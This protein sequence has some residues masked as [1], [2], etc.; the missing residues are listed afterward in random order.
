MINP[1]GTALKPFAPGILLALFTILFGFGIGV[2]F[3]AAEDSM[4]AALTDSG[5]AVLDTVY[6]GDV[7]KM[8]GVVGKSWSY[9]KRA[10]LHAGAIGTSAL[11]TTVVLFLLGTPRRL[12]RWSATAFGAGALLYSVFWLAAAFRAPGLGSTDLAK[13]S[14]AWIALPGSALAV[15]G[16]CGAIIAI[17]RR[18]VFIPK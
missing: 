4:K 7:A 9:V 14:L 10:H 6:Q 16:L 2:V 13:D 11:A 3:G 12:E 17:F 15:L 1:N 18:V 5:K 8:E